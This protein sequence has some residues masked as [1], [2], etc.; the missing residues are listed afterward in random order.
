[1]FVSISTKNRDKS[2]KTSQCI[3]HHICYGDSSSIE[4]E[5]IQTSVFTYLSRRYRQNLDPQRRSIQTLCIEE[6]WAY[7][8]VLL[9]LRWLNAIR[10]FSLRIQSKEA[11]FLSAV[12]NFRFIDPKVYPFA[13]S[14]SA[15]A[16][17]RA[18]GIIKTTGRIYRQ[19][20]VVFLRS[21]KIV[22]IRK[23]FDPTR[24]LLFSNMYIELQWTVICCV[25]A[26]SSAQFPKLWLRLLAPKGSV[27]RTGSPWIFYCSFA[28]KMDIEIH[29][30]LWGIRILEYFM[31]D[32]K[33]YFSKAGNVEI[34]WLEQKN[35]TIH[36]AS[37]IILS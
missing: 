6:E 4:T 18:E 32:L 29:K 35:Q 16:Q 26:L 15:V 22:F 7:A 3:P 36:F 14:Q 5:K 21:A 17:V 1:M 30:D 2:S 25:I 12:E 37:Y 27:Q 8:E 20:Y 23:Y 11:S 24:A 33:D 9:W 34:E 19:E 31:K 13:D 28:S 10:R